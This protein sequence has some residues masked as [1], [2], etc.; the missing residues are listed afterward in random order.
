MS[1][2]RHTFVPDMDVLKKELGRMP[3][4]PP[5][6]KPEDY[7]PK[8]KGENQAPYLSQGIKLVMHRAPGWNG[9]RANEMEA[10]D[11]IATAISIILTDDKL[12]KVNWEK[13]CALA[14]GVE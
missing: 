4:P 1:D 13:I 5:K 7:A 8:S 12:V 11:L 9:L 10:L 14:E 2:T 3:D 6:D